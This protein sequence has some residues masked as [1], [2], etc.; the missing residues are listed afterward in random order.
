MKI[1]TLAISN[2]WQDDAFLNNNF[3]AE[4][5]QD[6]PR[7]QPRLGDRSSSFKLPFLFFFSLGV[8]STKPLLILV[9]GAS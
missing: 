2:F 6:I 7:L 4:L 9:D 5:V 8:L 1:S 3:S